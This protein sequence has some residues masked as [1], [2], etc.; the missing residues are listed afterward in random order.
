MAARR[1]SLATYR[2]PALPS[3]VGIVHL[4]IGAFHRAHQA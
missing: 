1:L 2:P 4:G 3:Q